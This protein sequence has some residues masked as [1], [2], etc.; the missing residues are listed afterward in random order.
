M[1]GGIATVVALAMMVVAGCGRLNYATTDAGADGDVPADADTG[2]PPTD[3]LLPSDADG[4]SSIVTDTGVIV[5]DGGTLTG[6]TL[7]TGGL[8]DAT[9]PVLTMRGSEIAIAWIDERN[10]VPE[11]Y[12]ARF[13]PASGARLDAELRV[14]TTSTGAQSPALAAS[15]A[16]YAVAWR[17]ASMT[18]EDVY[19]SLLDPSGSPSAGPLRITSASGS[20]RTIAVTATP[21]GWFVG[22]SERLSGESR[23]IHLARLDTRGAILDADILVATANEASGPAL[24]TA[25][26][27][28]DVLWSA[29]GLNLSRIL[30][31]GTGLEPPV[32]LDTGTGGGDDDD[33]ANAVAWSGSELG[34]TWRVGGERTP[35]QVAFRRFNADGSIAG[36][37]QQLS[38]TVG[39]ARGSMVA[40]GGDA[41]HVVWEDRDATGSFTN[42]FGRRVDEASMGPIEQISDT[43]TESS[44]PTVAWSAVMSLVVWQDARTGVREIFI[45]PAP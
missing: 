27:H 13:D 10:A 26:P 14:T 30:H 38:E 6:P 23:A 42:V 20:Y 31:D 36:P 2:S 37:I 32:S 24:V 28:V 15:A 5:T 40:W 25:G 33:G 34:V 12:F 43:T 17:Q 19:V 35:E 11:V 4:D 45:S 3:A 41:F 21:T 16:G 7:L 22:W 39:D 29:S 44:N 18:G 8:A 1:V 9:N